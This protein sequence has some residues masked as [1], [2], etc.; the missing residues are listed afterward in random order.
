[1]GLA[2][3]VRTAGSGSLPSDW[4]PKAAGPRRFRQGEPVSDIL[5]LDRLTECVVELTMK[6]AINGSVGQDQ[7]TLPAVQKVFW[8][9]LN[10]LLK[11]RSVS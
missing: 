1:M 7:A 3:K 8:L 5:G 11:L 10:A 6:P 4:K 9:A 2:G